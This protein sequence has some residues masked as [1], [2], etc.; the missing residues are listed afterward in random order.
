M[1]VEITKAEQ[2]TDQV[3]K[4]EFQTLDGEPLP[5]WTAG[6]HLDIVVAPEFLRQYSMSGDPADNSKYQIGVLREAAGRGGS[7]L[8][9][10]IFTEGTE[11]LYF[12]AHQSF[13]VRRNS[14]QKLFDGAAVLALPQ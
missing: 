8:L 11:N 3:T 4:Y 6:A 10:R 1:R 9:H 13:P 12:Q 5:D 7:E 2:M 14:Q